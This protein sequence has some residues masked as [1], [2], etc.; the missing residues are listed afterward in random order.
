MR[1]Q[2]LFKTWF[3]AL[4]LAGALPILSACEMTSEEQGAVGT[5]LSADVRTEPLNP[6]VTPPKAECFNERYVQPEAEI[7]RKIDLLFV[8]DTSGSLDEE[9]LGIANGIDSFVAALPAGIDLN[10]AVMLAHG[11]TSSYSGKIY[12]SFKGEPDVLKSTQLNMTDL[13]KY[14][15]YK[16]TYVNEDYD[17]D[18]G[19]TGMFSLQ[20]SLKTDKLA[21]AQGKGFYRSDAALVVVFISDENDICAKFPAGV[22]RV[23]D[24]QGTEASSFNRDCV[25]KV[26]STTEWLITAENTYEKLKNL[27]GNRPLLVGAIVYN[28]PATYPRVGENEYGYGW[29]DVVSVAHGI[30]I[31]MAGGHYNEGLAQIG[32]LAT[33]KLNLLSDFT[34]ARTGFDLSTLK[35][36]VDGAP[37]P[38]EYLSLM[39]EVHLPEPGT[40]LSVIDIDYCMK[41]ATPNPEPTLTPS[42]TPTPSPSP[43]P[44]PDP[45]PTPTPTPPPCEG[46]GCGVIG[47]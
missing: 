34:L 20:N 5:A 21:L 47:V 14:L 33:I 43:S 1:N 39:N 28:N 40:A 2:T 17:A 18:G 22:T 42:P 36:R 35:V 31:D 32:S 11:S 24:P 7:T 16:L 30:S 10:I 9:R 23:P 15:G 29:L 13:R 26:G 45:S 6:P 46:L 41:A 8:T 37:S 27:Q 19:E 38:F 3:L 44:T 12:K 25:K 4:L